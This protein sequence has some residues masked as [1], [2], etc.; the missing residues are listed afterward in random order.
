MDDYFFVDSGVNDS[1]Y[2]VSAVWDQCGSFRHNVLYSHPAPT[3]SSNDNST[4]GPATSAGIRTAGIIDIV[5]AAIVGV[6]VVAAIIAF[7]LVR[8]FITV[9]TDT[10]RNQASIAVPSPKEL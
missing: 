4:S 8:L 2:R 9:D 3:D 6:A 5:A 10:L 7:I 1:H